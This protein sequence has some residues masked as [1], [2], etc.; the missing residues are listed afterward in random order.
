M[1]HP[2]TTATLTALAV[3]ALGSA[4]GGLAAQAP[5]GDRPMVSLHTVSDLDDPAMIR[6]AR[7]LPGFD[8]WLTPADFPPEAFN[9]AQARVVQ[10]K[11][12]VSA[13][14]A[15]TDCQHNSPWPD[16][17]AR[18]CAV[19]RERGRFLHAL[20]AAGRAQIG[21]R[22]MSVAFRVLRSGESDRLSPAP[23][24]MGYQNTKPVIRDA[25]LL[26]L[27]ADP[28]RFIEPRPSLWLDVN[29]KGRVTRCRIRT[30]TGTDAGDAELCRRMTKAKFD[31]ARDP[32]GNKVPAAGHYVALEVAA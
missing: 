9:P 10:V 17:A 21:T 27:K 2:R 15:V 6:A 7:P 32:Q 25:A 4:W 18:A 24:P 16:L 1:T 19:L 5:S 14:G 29:A 20:D 30:S 8:A 23:P 11:L 28:Q 3:L 31:P 12:V 13:A 26:R 22:W